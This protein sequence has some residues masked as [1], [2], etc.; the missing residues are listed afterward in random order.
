MKRPLRLIRRRNIYRGHIIRLI[1]EEFSCRG[2]R[3]IRETILHPGA[4]VVLP[5]LPDGRLILVRQYRRAVD[6]W[7][8]ELPAGTLDRPRESEAACARR[9]FDF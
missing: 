1:Q 9:G 6:R 2:R 8:L 5:V 4:V 3:I 7:L